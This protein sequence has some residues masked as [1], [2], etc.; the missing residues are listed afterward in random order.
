MTLPPAVHGD[1]GGL[2]IQFD[3]ISDKR[4]TLDVTF[5]AIHGRSV[6]PS[7]VVVISLGDLGSGSIPVRYLRF[8][9]PSSPWKPNRRLVA[10][11]QKDNK[12]LTPTCENG[13]GPSFQLYV[14]L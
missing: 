10:L 7:A 1:G 4:L 2:F 13:R 14:V 5:S 9:I 3:G 11:L 6:G 8:R 12:G